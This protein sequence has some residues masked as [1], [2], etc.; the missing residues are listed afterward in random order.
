MDIESYL[1]TKRKLYGFDFIALYDDKTG[2][3]Q[4]A[5]KGFEDVNREELT[6]NDVFGQELREGHCASCME[7]ERMVYAVKTGSASEEKT[8]WAAASSE[9][10]T[11]IMMSKTFQEKSSTSVVRGRREHG[12]LESCRR[13]EGR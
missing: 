6:E 2:E 7:E 11:S 1:E 10:I 12:V 5:G 9:E 4:L 13:T 8:L 3:V